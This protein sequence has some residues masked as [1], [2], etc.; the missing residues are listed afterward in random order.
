[1]SKSHG[2]TSMYV[3]TVINFAKI[4]TYTHILRTYYVHTTYYVQN[5]WSHSLS[6]ETK[7]MDFTVNAVT[8]NTLDCF[9]QWP[10]LPYVP[11]PDMA[12]IFQ[13][14]VG[15]TLHVTLLGMLTRHKCTHAMSQS[16]IRTFSL[17]RRVNMKFISSLYNPPVE[18]A[19]L[20][21]THTHKKKKKKRKEKQTTATKQNK[22][23]NWISA[24]SLHTTH[25]NF[26]QFLL[27]C[28]WVWWWERNVCTLWSS[29]HIP[30]L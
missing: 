30:S 2:N 23:K 15:V 16:V 13:F 29:L 27:P 1:M 6:G 11:L 20:H 24:G 28:T 10:S 17:M 3:D 26:P 8:V 14:W 5:Q 9:H 25:P 18:S 12:Y 22:N 21:C 19:A 4:T 7:K